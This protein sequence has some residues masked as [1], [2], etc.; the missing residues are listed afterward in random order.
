MALPN[1]GLVI[2]RP[3]TALVFTDLQNDFLS[4]G[5]AA[6]EFVKD[7]LAAN[8]ALANMEALLRYGDSGCP[9]LTSE[10]LR[11]CPLNF[12]GDPT[13]DPDLAD[14]MVGPLNVRL[15]DAV[16]L[17]M[18]C[19]TFPF[20]TSKTRRTDIDHTIP[21]QPNG[22][23]GQTRIGNLAPLTRRSHRIKT[24]GRWHVRQ[25]FP[26][27]HIWRSPHGTHYLVDHTGTRRLPGTPATPA[28]PGPRRSPVLVELWRSPVRLE[29]D[30]AA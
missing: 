15:R 27:I 11:L 24:H 22:P 23:P 13:F 19:D 12:G 4:P 26:G 25:P 17:L 16:H 3:H 1:P 21:H 10:L 28:T 14:D 8:D 5:G 18:P 6:W 29:L 20:A 7:G 30:Y 9:S 2:E